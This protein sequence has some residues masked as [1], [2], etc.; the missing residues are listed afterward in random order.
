MA[1]FPEVRHIFDETKHMEKSK[2]GLYSALKKPRKFERQGLRA[3]IT[4]FFFFFAFS[5]P[6][7]EFGKS[8]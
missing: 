8:V 3:K 5:H 1:E 2:C 6:I 7:C 4:Y